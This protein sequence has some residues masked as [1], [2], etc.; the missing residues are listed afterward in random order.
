MNTPTTDRLQWDDDLLLGNTEIDELHHEFVEVVSAVQSASDADM[1]QHF[2][3]LL[4][5]LQ[6]HF[7]TE[8]EMMRST[9]FPQRDCH[10]DEHAAVLQSG[11][12]V[13]AELQ[14][15]NAA[16]CHSYA[17]ALVDWF[18]AHAQH[19]DSAVVHWVSKIR[20]G[21]KPVVIKRNLAQKIKAEGASV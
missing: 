18:P 8:D 14:K 11:R 13:E 7:S 10:I 2:A 19:L 17:A 3:A 4:D 21:G 15:G 5:H 20:T 1:P 6:R 16:I 9:D 12:E